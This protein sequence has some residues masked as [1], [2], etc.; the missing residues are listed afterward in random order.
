MLLSEA[1]SLKKDERMDDRLFTKC[2]LF[3]SNKWDQVPGNN[4]EQVKQMQI[5]KL[6][7]RLGDLNPE[8][9]I[10]YLSCNRAQC[11]QKYGVITEEFDKLLDGISNLV[12]SYMQS[13]LQIYF[14]WAKH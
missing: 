7:E 10:F 4:A 8:K 11:A 12:V 3:V 2:A 14:R 5:E 9:Q 13:S 1:K 6:T